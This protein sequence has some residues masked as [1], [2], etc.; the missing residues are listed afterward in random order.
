M[1]WKPIRPWL[2]RFEVRCWP[3]EVLFQEVEGAHAVDGVRPVK[4]LDFG[5]IADAQLFV[6]ATH[7]CVFV[8]PTSLEA[9]KRYTLLAFGDSHT[10]PV[11]LVPEQSGNALAGKASVRVVNSLYSETPIT[12][13]LGATTDS[14]ATNGFSSGVILASNLTAGEFSEPAFLNPG[15]LPVTVFTSRSPAGLL[16][17][18]VPNLLPDKKYLLVISSGANDI[19]KATLIEENQT[20]GNAE[21]L[22]RGSFVEI[23]NA[24]GETEYITSGFDRVLSGAKLYFS[25]SIAT[26]LPS[27]NR[28]LTINGIGSLPIAVS[29]DSSVLAIVTGMNVS[30]ILLFSSHVGTI[31]QSSSRRRYINASKD[32]SEVKITQDSLNGTLIS[33]GLPSRS[34]VDVPAIAEQRITLVFSNPTTQEIYSRIEN[35]SFPLG[36]NYSIIFIGSSGK[37]SAIIEQEF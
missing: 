5:A 11:I 30:D 20:G 4:K 28:S 34:T 36:K 25:N 6:N 14:K 10:F 24:I 31:L 12:V 2:L 19:T 26:I 27:G 8:G 29:P 13:S 17:G 21:E 18:A 1:T 9:L 16:Y 33:P 32:V 37:Y 23:V 7:A 22:P 3:V 35:V 15:E